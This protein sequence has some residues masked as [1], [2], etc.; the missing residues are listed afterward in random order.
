[1]GL[2]FVGFYIATFAS[3]AADGNYIYTVYRLFPVVAA[4]AITT[5][6]WVL[7]GNSLMRLF[8][9]A[10]LFVVSWLV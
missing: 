3:I 5:A 8:Y 1:V 2:A 9:L 6:M 7:P 4:I 10:G